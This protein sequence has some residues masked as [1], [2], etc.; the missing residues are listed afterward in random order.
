[1]GNCYPEKNNV[2]RGEADT[3]DEDEDEDDTELQ[4]NYIY[5]DNVNRNLESDIHHHMV[6]HIIAENT[7][8]E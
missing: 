2:D 5:N 7:L 3:E 4:C 8:S 6:F 1:M